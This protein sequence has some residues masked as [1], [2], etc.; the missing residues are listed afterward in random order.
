M[1]V[2]SYVV[3]PRPGEAAS[4][5]RQLSRVEGC[6]VVPAENADFLLLVTETDSLDEDAA[7]RRRVEGLAGI[8]ALL[9]TFGEVDPEAPVG[10]PLAGSKRRR[11]PPADGD[12]PSEAARTKNETETRP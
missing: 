9:M 6:E 2:C 7:V 10:D 3:V 12:D 8:Q 11:P 4:V 5:A 1:P